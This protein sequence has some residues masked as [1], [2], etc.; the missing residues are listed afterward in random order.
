MTSD[1]IR[2]VPDLTQMVSPA[3]KLM[4]ELTK[5]I[6]SENKVS[7]FIENNM[8]G[9]FAGETDMAAGFLIKMMMAEANKDPKAVLEKLMIFYN[10]FRI[11]YANIDQK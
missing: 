11:F 7:L 2:G 1:D 8:G 10:A 4:E 5:D 3:M 9:L 6:K